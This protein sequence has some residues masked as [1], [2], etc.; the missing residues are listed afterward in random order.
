MIRCNI[1][2]AAVDNKGMATFRVTSEPHDHLPESENEPTRA[3]R[4]SAHTPPVKYV[5]IGRTS[6]GTSRRSS[7]SSH[8]SSSSVSK[9]SNRSN[10][11]GWCGEA[12][13]RLMYN[14]RRVEFNFFLLELF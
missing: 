9:S 13:L 10:Q 11:S 14:I 1:V 3:P 12:N 2:I 7:H 8:S 6:P 4:P 5:S